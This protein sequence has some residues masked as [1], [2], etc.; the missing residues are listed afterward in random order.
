[1]KANDV[2]TILKEIISISTNI[3]KQVNFRMES[4]FFTIKFQINEERVA[5]FR[6]QISEQRNSNE[7]LKSKLLTKDSTIKNQNSILEKIQFNNDD[8][9]K[10]KYFLK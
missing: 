2:T 4:I 8:I 5:I 6:R 7:I 3:K 9:C 10:I 1:M